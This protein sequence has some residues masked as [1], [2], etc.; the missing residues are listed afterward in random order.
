[1]LPTR[2][3][4]H[5][6]ATKNILAPSNHHAASR[7]GRGYPNLEGHVTLTQQQEAGPLL[8]VNLVHGNLEIVRL[9]LTCNFEYIRLRVPRAIFSWMVT[10]APALQV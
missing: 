9:L 8:K 6:Y 7:R 3:H 4:A 2:H 1:M 5:R 10:G